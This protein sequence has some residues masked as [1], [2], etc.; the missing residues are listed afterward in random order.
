MHISKLI[1]DHREA[2]MSGF[3]APLVLLLFSPSLDFPCRSTV[4]RLRYCSWPLTYRLW[5]AC[6]FYYW[7]KSFPKPAWSALRSSAVHG[8]LTSFNREERGE[9]KWQPG[10]FHLREW[11]DGADLALVVTSLLRFGFSSMENF[12]SVPLGHTDV[13]CACGQLYFVRHF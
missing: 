11:H 6:L 1:P 4:P 8:S 10:D 2:K 7:R 13:S 3:M 9:T 5:R 12:L